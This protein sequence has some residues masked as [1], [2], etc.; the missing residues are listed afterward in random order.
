MNV[1]PTA[2]HSSDCS[3][4]FKTKPT[5]PSKYAAGNAA[6]CGGE[7]WSTGLGSRSCSSRTLSGGLGACCPSY[8][9]HG[10]ILD[11]NVSYVKTLIPFILR[12]RMKCKF[13]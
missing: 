13:R 7:Y 1:V 2:V 6:C 4:V 5:K 12:T 11:K 9:V 10:I 8:Q 3:T